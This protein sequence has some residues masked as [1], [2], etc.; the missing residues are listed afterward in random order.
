MQLNLEVVSGTAPPKEAVALLAGNEELLRNTAQI[1]VRD[2][3]IIERTKA[4]GRQISL[5]LG[6]PHIHQ[7]V[8]FLRLAISNYSRIGYDI[9]SLRFLIK[10]KKQAKRTAVQETALSTLYVLNDT[11]AVAGKSEHVFVFALPKFT[12][13]DQKYLVI[14]LMEK[15][16]G[17]HMELRI[18][19]RPV[20]RA[21]SVA[22]TIN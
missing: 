15:N 14:Q 18:G 19:N 16:G 8:L 3:K 2:S 22:D 4:P 11:T 17:R 5:S 20:S 9:Q 21:R 13:P 12:I 1:V 6:R 7:D 10:D